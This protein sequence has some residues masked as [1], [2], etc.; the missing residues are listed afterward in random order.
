MIEERR[1]ERTKFG[2][3]RRLDFLDR[4]GALRRRS[5]ELPVLNPCEHMLIPFP[6]EFAIKAELLEHIPE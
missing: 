2:Q 4:N 1:A 6:Q 5:P 3:W